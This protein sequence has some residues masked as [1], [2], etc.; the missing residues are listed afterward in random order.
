MPVECLTGLEGVNLSWLALLKSTIKK[1]EDI[2][3]SSENLFEKM[4]ICLKVK[5]DLP[6]PNRV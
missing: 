2:T 6:K 3:R 5:P 4:Q 1:E